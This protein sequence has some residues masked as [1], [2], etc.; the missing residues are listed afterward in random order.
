MN[1][2]LLRIG[3][4]FGY[5]LSYYREILRGIKSFAKARPRWTFTPISPDP[6][7]VEAVRPLD[8]DGFIAH[9]FTPGLGKAARPPPKAGDQ[10]LRGPARIVD[11]PSW[12]RS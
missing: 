1:D 5:G 8:H 10:R 2:R 3:L 11:A 7:A 9:V 4:V 6:Q 12:G